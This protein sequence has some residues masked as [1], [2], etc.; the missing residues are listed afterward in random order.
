[1]RTTLRI[2]VSLAFATAANAAEP[3]APLAGKIAVGSPAVNVS[4]PASL[5][6][7]PLDVGRAR[8]KRGDDDRSGPLTFAE[9]RRINLDIRHDGLW[10]AQS[11]GRLQWQASI[12]V[13]GATDL[14]LGFSELR[15]PEGARLRMIGAD[16]HTFQGPYHDHDLRRD[17]RFWSPAVPGERVTLELDVD[18]EGAAGVVLRVEQVGAGF[19]DLYGRDGGPFLKSSGSCNI[20]VACPE[21]D[22]WREQ[23]RSV[24]RYQ[25]NGSTLCTGTLVRDVA[26]SGRALLLTAAH[27]GVTAGNAASVVVYWNY[28]SPL[29]G[30]RDGGSLAQ[31]QSGATLRAHRTDVD[32]AL[33][34]LDVVP[35]P[36][37][38]VHYAGW[39][40]RLTPPAGSV[41]IHHPRAHVKALAINLDPLTVG[42]SCIVAG[43]SGNTHWY[44]DNWEV[45]TTQS[46][47]SGSGLWDPG[48][49]RLVGF[50]SGGA[51]S[52]NII[53]YDCYGRFGVAW[54]GMEPGARLRDWLDPDG[55]S[56]DAVDGI[57]PPPSLGL[58]L[59]SRPG[60]AIADAGPAL[61]DTLSLDDSRRLTGLRLS[62][63]IHHTWVGDLSARLSHDGTEVLL[64]DRPGR[65][66]RTH[67][68][69]GNDVD[70]ILDDAADIGVQT[71]CVDS[72]PAYPRGSRLAPRAA[73]AAF[74]G[75]RLRGDW[76]LTVTDHAAA[77]VGSLLEWC[78]VPALDPRIT[79]DDGFE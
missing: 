18:A 41:G 52:C 35:D 32:M 57:D 23:I 34:E 62:L 72:N 60:T 5:T 65:P 56:P 49:G 77:D 33:L 79:F 12:E 31:N 17:G 24:A 46:G 9:P 55:L 43:G 68:C 16:G 28:Q 58:P 59:C 74:A 45:G 1:M 7:A 25:I 75:Q 66:Q 70:L 21:G 78:L 15:L 37:F 40:R 48:S 51:A 27:C 36:A 50:L 39:D 69:S 76:Q 14:N 20:D 30:Q 67:G 42:P 11:D 3:E 13:P 38:D 26:G 54:D 4:Q 8:G 61:I 53:D 73:L 63:R 64:F 10:Q 71:G 22:G 19:L 29:C 44:V 47:S 2:F 6:L